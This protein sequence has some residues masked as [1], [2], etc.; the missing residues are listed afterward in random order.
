MDEAP[1]SRRR[2]KRPQPP[3][4]EPK[5]AVMGRPP[6]DINWGILDILCVQEQPLHCIAAAMAKADG[7]PFPTRED[8]R[9]YQERI[10]SALNRRYAPEGMTFTAYREKMLQD[11]ISN[12]R[13]VLWNEGLEKRNTAILKL[14]AGHYAG[15]SEKV[16][17]THES[18]VPV[19]VNL[20]A[21][22]QAIAA[23][24]FAE[25]LPVESESEPEQ[26]VATGP[27]GQEPGTED[28][29]ADREDAGADHPARDP[30]ESP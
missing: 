8:E 13:E 6:I 11:R 1:P 22:K 7:V 10:T 4:E 3:K 5:R 18:S 25:A 30:F 17:Q 12:L 28:S 29:G 23:D 19:I 16:T 27:V 9:K 14:L 15:M 2:G 21:V 24:P 26:P 20:A